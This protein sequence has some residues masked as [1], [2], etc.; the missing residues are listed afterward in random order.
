MKFNWI[1]IINFV[2]CKTL[3][4]DMGNGRMS[5][6]PEY[7]QNHI[8][9][10]FSAVVLDTSIQNEI[11]FSIPNDV[12][13]VAYIKKKDNGELQFIFQ[14]TYKKDGLNW[15]QI[16]TENNEFAFMINTKKFSNLVN[17]SFSYVI[18]FSHPFRDLLLEI[19]EP[20]AA[21]DFSYSGFNGEKN[22]DENGIST[23]TTSLVDIAPNDYKLITLSY[24]NKL[25]KTT[26]S[27]LSELSL[28]SE[29][30]LK[31]ESSKKINRHKLYIW[32]PIIVL[33]VITLFTMLIMIFF[34]NNSSEL[35]YC[36]NCLQKMHHKNNFCPKCG[37]K[38]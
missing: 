37:E 2:L 25:E 31:P 21:E 9:I 10:L 28:N 11:S 14:P 35:Y 15:A 30:H 33:G 20:L 36:S 27:I 32:E 24:N 23:Y 16:T 1:F 17:R 22:I 3:I 5:I 19:Q 6:I 12:D 26:Q 8:T 18:S 29:E 13:S 4:G 38:I 34:E 7:D